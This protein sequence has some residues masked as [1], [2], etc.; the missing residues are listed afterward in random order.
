MISRKTMIAIGAAAMAR[1]LVF[2]FLRWLTSFQNYFSKLHAYSNAQPSLILI[3]ITLINS[4]AMAGV[5]VYF[6]GKM[7]IKSFGQSFN[8]IVLAWLG[9]AI[10]PFWDQILHFG[11]PLIMMLNL[12][13]LIIMA[14]VLVVLL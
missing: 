9:F 1:T 13:D 5:L 10:L 12:V 3:A 4:L 11:L 6:I 14:F 2:Y 7:H 8:F